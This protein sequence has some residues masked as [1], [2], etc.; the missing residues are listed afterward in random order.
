MIWN[1]SFLSLD[2]INIF[3]ISVLLLFFC[4]VVLVIYFKFFKKFNLM[5]LQ[6]LSLYM[7]LEESLLSGFI[8]FWIFGILNFKIAIFLYLFVYVFINCC[9]MANKL[10]RYL[11]ETQGINILKIIKK[12][13]TSLLNLHQT[14]STIIDRY[15]FVKKDLNRIKLLFKY[16][17]SFGIGLLMACAFI[18][19]N[20]MKGQNCFENVLINLTLLTTILYYVYILAYLGC[21][22]N[23]ASKWYGKKVSFPIYYVLYCSIFY[24]LVILIT[25]N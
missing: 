9:F 24:I 14:K 16:K 4:L 7:Y 19:L 11:C 5:S 8:Y 3:S 21:V 13:N 25:V 15:V 6:K 2:N 10:V 20:D 12:E 17:H 18:F 1:N 23:Q 22:K